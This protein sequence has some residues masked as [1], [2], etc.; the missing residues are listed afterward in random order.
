MTETYAIHRRIRGEDSYY[1]LRWSPYYRLE[2]YLIRN[3]V[4]AE[5]A[6]YQI[7][8]RE[9]YNLVLLETNLAF[10]GGVRETFAEL[11]D[12]LSPR[13]YPHRDILLNGE[14]YG[15]FALSP[16]KEFLE[17]VKAYLNNEE[18]PDERTGEIFVEEIDT[19]GIIR[20]EEGQEA[21]EQGN[22]LVSFFV[23]NDVNRYNQGK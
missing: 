3:K 13:F 1:K 9:S 18:V 7:Y 22:G 12:S 10:Y 16:H 20:P 11:I 21:P 8:Y 4:P 15:R 2:K 19:K 23:G 6:V 14:C 17:D 5:S